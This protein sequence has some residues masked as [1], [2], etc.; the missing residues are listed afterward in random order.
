[1]R[2]STLLWNEEEQA[3]GF[4]WGEGI[5]SLYIQ[6]PAVNVNF[7]A[8]PL[9]YPNFLCP[10][11]SMNTESFCGSLCV[12]NPVVNTHVHMHWGRIQEPLPCIVWSYSSI[13]SR[14]WSQRSL[15]KLPTYWRASQTF[16]IS[17]YPGVVDFGQPWGP[18]ECWRRVWREAPE[19]PCAGRQLGA[20][21]LFFCVMYF[22]GPR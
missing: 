10:H 18:R 4:G 22:T 13:L 8:L 12:T 15:S 9:S 5:R 6:I 11:F 2:C 3:C 16:P 20:A 7:S 17:W 21:W 14:L 19:A 1:M